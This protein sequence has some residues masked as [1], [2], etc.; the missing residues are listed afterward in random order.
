MD[1]PLAVLCARRCL[2]NL[3]RFVEFQIRVELIDRYSADINLYAAQNDF[4]NFD[5]LAAAFCISPFKRARQRICRNVDL[6]QFESIDDEA[7]AKQ[8]CHIHVEPAAGSFCVEYFAE[9]QIL[10]PHMRA[11]EQCHP[12]AAGRHIIVQPFRERF[13]QP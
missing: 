2:D 3:A 4:S 1:I 12:E 5:A 9:R 13:F 11:R 7:V 6:G 8:G 10:D